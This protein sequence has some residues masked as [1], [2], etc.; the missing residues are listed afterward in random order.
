MSTTSPNCSGELR[1]PSFIVV[2][3]TISGSFK[4]AYDWMMNKVAKAAAHDL[5]GREEGEFAQLVPYDKCAWHC[6]PSFWEGKTGLNKYSIGIELV[7]WGPL[8]QDGNGALYS[9]L[10]GTAVTSGEVFYG[11]PTGSS[12][13]VWQGYTAS[14]LYKLEER[15]IALREQFPSIKEVIGHRDISPG[16]KQDPWPLEPLKTFR[17]YKR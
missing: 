13:D 7:S 9:A 11:A 3:S 5:I 1:E 12:Y 14:Q 6:G 8:R 10:H 17:K 4:S 15:I 16:R 2:H